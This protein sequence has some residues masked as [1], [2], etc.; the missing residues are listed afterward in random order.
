[1]C[2][3][4]LTQAFD[5]VRLT[6]VL[7]L[8]KK[9][10]LGSNIYIIAI[11][12]Q[13]NTGNSTYIKTGNKMTN[14]IPVAVGIRQGDS[15]I[16]FNI[17]MDEIIE[18]VKTAGRGYSMERN[19]IKIVCYADDAVIISENEDNLQK[20]LYKFEKAAERLNEHFHRENKISHNI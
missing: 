20:L 5:R 6:D 17:I 14:K 15:S 19:E 9:R 1:M 11:I 7:N 8:L 2:F 12:E 10:K 13:L 4:D 3:V 16:L 18:E